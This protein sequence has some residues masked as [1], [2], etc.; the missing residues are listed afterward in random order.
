[1]NMIQQQ[2]NNFY[3]FFHAMSWNIPLYWLLLFYLIIV[4]P[5]AF[6]VATLLYQ[7]QR[8]KPVE[9][10]A[11]TAWVIAFVVHLALWVYM[12]DAVLD[13]WHRRGIDGTQVVVTTGIPLVYALLRALPYV[14]IAAFDV[15]WIVKLVVA[16]KPKAE[17]SVK[18]R[19]ARV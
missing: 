19:A 5:V 12:S 15:F 11:Y 9:K 8:K 4:Y 6:A 14:L 3:T 10:T 13:A 18:R 7:L 2:L 17:A 1:M 16:M